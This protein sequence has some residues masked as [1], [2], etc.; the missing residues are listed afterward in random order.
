MHCISTKSAIVG[1]AVAF[2]TRTPVVISISGFGFL[3]QS[4]T[5][6]FT[7]KLKSIFV[8]NYFVF[9]SKFITSRYIIQNK[10]DKTA[11]IKTFRITDESITLTL[12][13]GVELRHYKFEKISKQNIVLMA[14]RL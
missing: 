6:T 7:D 8:T 14:S 9:L 3:F 10:R 13:S 2:F 5:K 11:L 12:G 1:L 4:G